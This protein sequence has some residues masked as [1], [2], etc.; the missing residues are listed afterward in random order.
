MSRSYQRHKIAWGR[1]TEG[2]ASRC[3]TSY[4]DDVIDQNRKKYGKILVR[5]RHWR[6]ELQTLEDYITWLKY[7]TGEYQNS[8]CKSLLCDRTL[9]MF[10]D[11]L[12]NREPTEELYREYAKKLYNRDRSK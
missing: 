10:K 7:L 3:K 4:Y 8:Y 6:S 5:K 11:F 9:S 12:N 2:G 1:A